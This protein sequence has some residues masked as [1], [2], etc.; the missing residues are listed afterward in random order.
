MNR[1]DL[2]F[3]V[4]VSSTFQDFIEERNALHEVFR[5]LREYCEHRGA[6]FQAI[7]LRWGIGSGE[8]C[9]QQTLRICLTELRRCQQ[10]SPKPNLIVL[11]G[12]RYGWIPL[13]PQI[14]ADE[15][16]SLLKHVTDPERQELCRWYRMDNN[17]VPAEY[18]LLPREGEYARH[19]T[20]MKEE[21]RLR[22][23]LSR[24]ADLVLPNTARDGEQDPRR[25]KYEESATHQE[26]RLGVLE[27]DEVD[28]HAFCYFRESRGS[29]LGEETSSKASE[30]ALSEEQHRLK[31]LKAELKNKLPK[32]NVHIYEDE[33]QVTK[34]CEDVKA[35]LKAVIDEEIKA[36]QRKSELQREIDAHWEFAEARTHSFRFRGE[37]VQRISRYV[38]SDTRSPL[39]IQGLPGSGKSSVL[40]ESALRMR[41]ANDKEAPN[42]VFRSVGATPTSSDLGS[43]LT[44]ICQELGRVFNRFELVPEDLHDLS[45]D[46]HNRLGWA[47]AHMHLVVYIDAIDQIDGVDGIE[48]LQWI[49]TVLPLHVRLVLSLVSRKTEEEGES[50]SALAS[51]SRL[52]KGAFIYMPPLS[53]SEGGTILDTWLSQAGRVLSPWEYTDLIPYDGNQRRSGRRLTEAQRSEVMSK[54]NECPWPLY[55][56]VAFQEARHWT[57]YDELR[58][59]GRD[60]HSI[61][62]DFYARL[63]LHERHGPALTSRS[64]A[65]LAAARIGLS[66]T[67]LLDILSRDKFVMD[68]FRERSPDSPHTEELPFIVWSRLWSDL[69]PYLVQRDTHGVRVFTFYHQ[70]VREVARTRYLSP[71][72]K[73]EI[74]RR[75]WE[76]YRAQGYWIDTAD[77][78]LKGSSDLRANMRKLLEYPFHCVWGTSWSCVRDALSEFE[79]MDAKLRNLGPRAIVTDYDL[80]IERAKIEEVKEDQES[81]MDIR[82]LSDAFRAIAIDLS[83]NPDELLSQMLARIESR[84]LRTSLRE[85]AKSR[86]MSGLHPVA[87]TLTH[88]PGTLRAVMDSGLQSVWC[89][90]ISADGLRAASVSRDGIRIW[91]LDTGREIFRHVEEDMSAVAIAWGPLHAAIG[92]WDGVVRIVEI[93]TG[94]SVAEYRG[95]KHTSIEIIDICFDKR[96]YSVASVCFDGTLCLYDVLQRE[97]KILSEGELVLY[98]RVAISNEGS[99]L[100]ASSHGRTDVWDVSSAK[101]IATYDED[102]SSCPKN[103]NEFFGEGFV[104]CRRISITPD[105]ETVA[106]VYEKGGF[107]VWKRASGR[108]CSGTIR[109]RGNALALTP[110]GKRAII[111]NDKGKL[112]VW[113]IEKIPAILLAEEE[114]HSAEV[115]SVTTLDDQ[116]VLSGARD[117]KVSRWAIPAMIKH[118]RRR[119][120]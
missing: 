64:L 113:D 68:E 61:L 99:T 14:A 112:Q 100:Y 79:F 56:Q 28:R 106:A 70:Q 53:P 27:A 32:G 114:A 26:I 109:G 120:I 107:C 5:N 83:H 12:D 118:H 24:A 110:N 34:L 84:R 16:D 9:Y 40:A 93:A 1:K 10:I 51:L 62:N 88:S 46:F 11:L 95:W 91:E 44:R 60:S 94:N 108:I 43:L 77:S 23:I 6:Q 116:H 33:Y 29:G 4:F 49:P 74:H 63:E 89:W 52:E 97:L 69:A 13:P 3:R 111:G 18:C 45:R 20:W 75:L 78:E 65:Y 21:D 72:K 19:E 37:L 59:L 86:A 81:V 55:L 115:I 102:S 71:D 30:G 2:T 31:D 76:Y 7:D 42:V 58:S 38:T 36:F 96:G 101:L 119:M 41:M 47:T 98:Q 92:H 82:Q 67:E 66:E 35:D 8:A 80:A 105:G 57:S 25:R 48:S 17:A 73:R 117:G 54:F 87:A 104:S 85:Q 39:V 90:L 15:F 22:A 50:D 103:C